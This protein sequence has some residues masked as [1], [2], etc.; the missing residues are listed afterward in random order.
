MRASPAPEQPPLSQ[1]AGESGSSPSGL[2]DIRKQT[3][4]SYFPGEWPKCKWRALFVT[5]SLSSCVSRV[6]ND[7]RKRGKWRLAHWLQDPRLLR[8]GSLQLPACLLMNIWEASHLPWGATARKTNLDTFCEAGNMLPLPQPCC[9]GLCCT[10]KQQCTQ[11]HLKHYYFA[12]CGSTKTS[13]ESHICVSSTSVLEVQLFCGFTPG[14]RSSQWSKS[15]GTK[16]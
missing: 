2:A 4:A 3:S 10:N 5:D 9:W 7:P 8:A 15:K 14:I 6:G 16:R 13:D 11:F 1:Q 12:C